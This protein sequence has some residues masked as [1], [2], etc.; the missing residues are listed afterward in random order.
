MAFRIQIRRDTAANWTTANPTLAQGEFGFEI[1]TGKIKIG[2]G[3]DD[4]TTLD[5]S[6]DESGDI[7]THIADLANPHAVTK[8]QVGLGNADNTSDLNKPISTAT[9]SAL[10]LKANSSHTHALSDLTQSGASSGQVAKWNGSSWAPANEAGGGSWGSITGTIDDQTDL[11][12]KF[13]NFIDRGNAYYLKA[14]AS[15]QGGSRLEMTTDIPGAGGAGLSAS[16]VSTGVVVAEFCSVSGFPNTTFIS[17]GVMTFRCQARQTAGTKVTRLFAEFYSRTNP[18]GV[19]TLLATSGL[20]VPL[21][22]SNVEV[23]GE[24]ATGVINGLLA[25]DRLLVK[26]VANVTGVGTDPDVTIDVQGTNYSR[27]SIPISQL[28]TVDLSSK[29]DVITAN[30]NEFIYQNNSGVIEGLPGFTR[31][32]V[33]GGKYTNLTF[34]PNNETGSID[35]HQNLTNIN[36]IANSDSLTVNLFNNQVAI[37]TTDAGFS[38]GEPG[39]GFRFHVN[40]MEHNGESDLGSIDFYNNNFSI[41][42]GTDP[43]DVRGIGYSFG[44]GIVNANVTIT[45]PLQG[46]GFQPQVHASAS[47]DS[48]AYVVAFYDFADINCMVNGYTSINLSPSIADVNNN[49]NYSGINLN[50][51]IDN[52]TGNASVNGIAVS[53]TY[54]DMGLTSS[55]VGIRVNPTISEGNYVAGLD[56]SMDNV[57]AYA[58]LQSS[59]TEQ[60]LTFEFN[61]VGDNDNYTLE[62]TA[63]ATAGAEVVSILGTDITVQI[64]DGV[65]T[66]TQIKN[67][68][69]AI[70]QLVAAIT[71]TISGVGSNTQDIF[72][73][74]NF[75]GGENP[76]QILAANLDGNVTISGSLSFGGALSIGKLS[77]FAS[78]AVVTGSGNPETIHGLITN[79]TVAAS[80]N[81][82]LADTIGINTA[83]LL[84]VGDNATVTTG[85]VGISALALPAVVTMGTGSTV[86]RITGGTFALSLDA[87]AGGGTIGNLE[88]CRSVAIPNGSTAVTRLVGYKMD[89]PFGDPG[90]TSWGFYESPGI[91]NYFAGNLLI[92]GTAGS[93]D[94]VTNSS[95][96]LEIKSTTKAFMNARMTTTERNA[97]TA[98]NGMQIYNSTTDKLQV[99]AAGSWVDLH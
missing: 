34:E 90:T 96:A 70:P 15:D 71:T 5:Y 16:G 6:F 44:L 13:S 55:F 75:S 77:A 53:G 10:D 76:G 2:N 3:T 62:Y 85:F 9:Q 72:G 41:G 89:L 37:D 92:G 86:D 57:T 20:S 95:V 35:I 23:G 66:A 12:N 33:S 27:I 39:S 63:G 8:T 87:G 83:M 68:V 32:T 18:G 52:F 43:I 40:N 81:L 59:L 11:K 56:V 58:G 54:G 80:A 42:N 46:Y 99:Y 60:D 51:T 26:I 22:G 91:N 97:L 78:Q 38:L 49:T 67:A 48:S 30:N 29:Q 50:P 64:E 31:S 61:A 25:T 24:I 79:P 1:D 28:T 69:D 74:V 19:E 93:D 73:P 47:L 7:S 88:L 45:G 98:V 14:S 82:T 36:P 17:S 84:T 4:W 21:T 94:T 65:S